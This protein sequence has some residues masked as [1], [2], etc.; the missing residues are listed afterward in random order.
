M[1]GGCSNSHLVTQILG[2]LPA[3]GA[4]TFC[5]IKAWGK[6]RRSF[7]KNETLQRTDVSYHLFIVLSFLTLLVVDYL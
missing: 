1:P 4:R 3:Q 2:L 6:F 7:K 5:K